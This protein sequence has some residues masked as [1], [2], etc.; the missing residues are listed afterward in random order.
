MAGALQTYRTMGL[1]PL[2][3]SFLQSA[4]IQD[5]GGLES[6]RYGFLG[7]GAASTTCLPVPL[8]AAVPAHGL[9][10]TAYPAAWPSS[11]HVADSGFADLEIR[12]A[13]RPR[14]ADQ[15]PGTRSWSPPRQER[16]IRQADVAHRHLEHLTPETWT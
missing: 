3:G 15:E 11:P 1:Y 16:F 6:P 14:Q 5:G 10:T 8:D 13:E 2:S 4:G 12:R 9:E 7:Q